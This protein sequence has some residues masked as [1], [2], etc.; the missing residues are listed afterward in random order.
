MRLRE[1]SILEVQTAESGMII[2]SSEPDYDDYSDDVGEY[3]TITEIEGYGGYYWSFSHIHSVS[4]CLNH[5]ENPPMNHGFDRSFISWW[6]NFNPNFVD[7]SIK[8]LLKRKIEIYHSTSELKNAFINNKHGYSDAI[9]DWHKLLELD[10]DSKLLNLIPKEKNIR[11]EKENTILIQFEGF[12]FLQY[13][14]IKINFDLN[15]DFQYFLNYMYQYIDK[16]VPAYSY[17]DKWI[18]YNSTNGKILKKEGNVDTRILKEISIK[19]N[20]KIIC[21]KI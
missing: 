13:I 5:L 9:F 16:E 15:K 7:E 12:H 10:Y 17:N 2:I 18:L 4:D 21:Y 6:L 3:F 1:N 19:K 8:P 20:D 14:N 11:H